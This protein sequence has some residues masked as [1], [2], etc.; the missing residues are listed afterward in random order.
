MFKLN[1][2]G[3]KADTPVRIGAGSAVFQVSFDG[4]TQMCQLAAYLMMPA[5]VQFYFQQMVA[6]TRGRKQSVIKRSQFG[7]GTGVALCHKTFVQFLIADKVIFQMSLRR[8]WFACN[9]STI[10]FA[11]IALFYQLV[12]AAEGFA[13]L[14]KE[15]YPAHRAVDTM[16]YTAED[17]PRLVVALLDV[18]FQQVSQAGVACLV[19]LNNLTCQF[20][21]S[22]KMVVFVQY[23]PPN[24]HHAARLGLRGWVLCRGF[25]HN[26]TDGRDGVAHSV[27]HV[28]VDEEVLGDE[29]VDT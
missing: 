1:L 12:H 16:Y 18:F 5:G 2:E 4:A 19:G 25:R 22:D 23:L 29:D 17:V 26:G 24:R 28:D 14:G 10:D 8:G 6:P 11:E 27:L 21:Q 9:H 13:G 3:M 7:I 20:V 15:H